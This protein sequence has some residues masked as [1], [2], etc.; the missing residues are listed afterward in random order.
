MSAHTEGRLTA[1]EGGFLLRADGTCIAATG[2]EQ[3]AANAR[4]LAA[5]WNACE[6]VNTDDIETLAASGGLVIAEEAMKRAVI[7]RG[8]LLAAAQAF[9]KY[10]HDGFNESGHVALMLLYADALRLAKA[11]VAKSTGAAP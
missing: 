3:D 4:R 9:I 7:E 1:E 2:G 6:K 8:E 11:A 5:C 10:D